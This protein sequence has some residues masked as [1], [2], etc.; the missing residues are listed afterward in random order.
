MSYA[1]VSTM[2]PLTT[3]RPAPAEHLADQKTREP[4]GIDGQL[5]DPAREG[6]FQPRALAVGGQLTVS[7]SFE[8]GQ[9]T[10]SVD[11]IEKPP[12]IDEHIVAGDPFLAPTLR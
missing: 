7:R 4:H 8:D 2:R 9:A 12:R 3:L 5:A 10:H 1:S 6:A 11:Q